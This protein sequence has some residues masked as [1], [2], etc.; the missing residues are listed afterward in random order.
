MFEKKLINKDL[1]KLGRAADMLWLSIGEPVMIDDNKGETREVS[2]YA[3]HFQCQWRFVRN[4]EILL[5]SHDIYNPY[6]KNLEYDDEWNWDIFGREKEKSSLFDVNSAELNNLFP[7][8]L[9]NLNY[10][11]THDLHIDFENGI[12]FNT[13]ITCTRKCEYYRFID[14]TSD[15]SKHIVIFDED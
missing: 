11:D 9:T 4:G 5:A 1:R 13:F 14:F 8:K 7:L 10:T 12:Y 2:E 6:D 3:I 15:E